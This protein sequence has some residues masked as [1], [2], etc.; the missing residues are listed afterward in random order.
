M[1]TK[2]LHRR[3][4]YSTLAFLL[5]LIAEV[6]II[7]GLKNMSLD[8]AIPAV[9]VGLIVFLAAIGRLYGHHEFWPQSTIFTKLMAN[10][11]APSRLGAFYLLFFIIHLGWIT[12]GSLNLFKSDN[13]DTNDVL[14]SVYTGCIG[15]FFLICF[16][17][18]GKVDKSKAKRV[19]LVSGISKLNIKK[20]TYKGDDIDVEVGI[21]SL[22]NLVPLVRFFNLIFYSKQIG[23]QDVKKLLILSSD[24]HYSRN[25]FANAAIDITWFIEHGKTQNPLFNKDRIREYTDGNGHTTYA[26]YVVSPPN[27]DLSFEDSHKETDNLLRTIIKIAA[28]Q[29]FPDQEDFINHLQ[30][31][32]TSSC[33]YDDFEQCFQN[34]DVAIKK[35]DNNQQ[36]LYFNLTPGTGIVGSLMTLFSIDKDRELYFYAQNSSKELLAVDKSKLPLENLLS[37][38]L[39]K[40]KE[41]E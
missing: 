22:F 17:P 8:F 4:T 41:K 2:L 19:V 13:Y 31:E 27:K 33:N 12:D 24:V 9:F 37:Q 15:L 14:I 32:F 16:F 40:I 11:I 38:A 23:V 35:E 6:Y 28:L 34:L 18:E 1:N 3:D 26:Y 25:F 30:I 36:L 7:Y 5:V 39:D 29:E 21:I 20:E 10:A